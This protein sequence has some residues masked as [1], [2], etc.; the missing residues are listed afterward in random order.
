MTINNDQ[1]EFEALRMFNVDSKMF[2]AVIEAGE[3]EFG[4]VRPPSD[5][6]CQIGLKDWV[7]ITR[8]ERA[9]TRGKHP[10]PDLLNL[11]IQ[12]IVG[13]RPDINE[14]AMRRSLWLTREF[15]FLDANDLEVGALASATQIRWESKS[16]RDKVAPL[17]GLKDRLSRAKKIRA[18]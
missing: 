8:G 17:S 7:K 9:S 12:T 18:N 16:G 13:D 5:S 11:A 3:R 6:I 4:Y 15:A 10:K 14:A 2:W 1:L